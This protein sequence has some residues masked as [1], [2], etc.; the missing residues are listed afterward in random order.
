MTKDAEHSFVFIN[1]LSTNPSAQVQLT[2]ERCYTFRTVFLFSKKISFSS[3]FH[4]E[5]PVE[6]ISLLDPELRFACNGETK[7]ILAKPLPLFSVA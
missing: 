2:R 6:A 1:H 4:A 3:K 7:T 5:I